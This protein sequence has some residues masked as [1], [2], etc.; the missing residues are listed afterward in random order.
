MDEKRKK[1]ILKSYNF[2]I[3]HF[4]VLICCSLLNII[5]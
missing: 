5:F 1:K 4:S 2:K 3:K